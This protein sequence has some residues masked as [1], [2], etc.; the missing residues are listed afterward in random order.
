MRVIA[1][2]AITLGLLAAVIFAI[3]RRDRQRVAWPPPPEAAIADHPVNFGYKITWLAV[4]THD[5]PKLAAALGLRDLAPCNWKTG[6][7]RAY[8][9]NVFFTPPLGE[10]T[11]A[12]GLSIPSADANDSEARVV[13]LLER[14]SAQFGEAQ[15]FVSHRVVDYHGW[16][17]FVDGKAVR[18]YSYLGEKGKELHDTGAHLD[19]EPRDLSNPNEAM[20]M[21]AASEWSIDPMTLDRRTDAAGLGW[22]AR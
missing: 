18:H 3:A 13:S 8:A 15:W 21:R 6:I 17:R 1:F 14:L 2:I 22:I 20:V 9:S 16:A 19:F 5:V 10:W 11:L 12:V 7:D 4:K